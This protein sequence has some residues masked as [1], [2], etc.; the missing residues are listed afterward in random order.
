MAR[1]LSTRQR[2]DLLF[3]V[4]IFVMGMLVPSVV[5]PSPPAHS[6][7]AYNLLSLRDCSEAVN[8][9]SVG[10]ALGF[11]GFWSG[12][13][14]N[15]FLSLI[16]ALKLSWSNAHTLIAATNAL[17]AAFFYLRQRRHAAPLNAALGSAVIV[18][19]SVTVVRAPI[20]WNPTIVPPL[21]TLCALVFLEAVEKKNMFLF[22][23]A[24]LLLT[25]VIDAHAVGLLLV[26]AAIIATLLWAPKPVAAAVLCPL[27]AVCVGMA[28]SPTAARLNWIALTNHGFAGF[29]GL[30]VPAAFGIWL[31]PKMTRLPASSV[32]GAFTL[33][34]L[35]CTFLLPR[36][37]S[38][39]LDH[40]MASRYLAPS[41][42]FVAL[43]ATMSLQRIGSRLTIRFPDWHNPL[44]YGLALVALLPMLMDFSPGSPNKL[45]ALAE[46]WRLDD[47]TELGRQFNE[48]H[49]RFS[50]VHLN[51]RTPFSFH[52]LSGIGAAMPSHMKPPNHEILHEQLILLPHSFLKTQPT[53]WNDLPRGRTPASWIQVPSNIRMERSR[54]CVMGRDQEPPRCEL[55]DRTTLADLLDSE[56]TSYRQRTVPT[57]PVLDR[58]MSRASS[59]AQWPIR[60]RLEIQVE[61]LHSRR[62]FI[63]LPESIPWEIGAVQRNGI[64]SEMHARCIVLDSTGNAPVVLEMNAVISQEQQQAAHF[65]IPALIDFDPNDKRLA[66]ILDP[67]NWAIAS[68]ES[69]H[70][71]VEPGR[72]D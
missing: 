1:P 30:A 11:G 40:S 7:T 52:L 26:P 45:N 17:I 28:I 47:A 14:W 51:L 36:I 43:F 55:L 41:V 46:V 64:R 67:R 10:N 4:L 44:R 12:N 42:G 31:R 24:W 72:S 27:A 68:S 25:L 54:A 71:C 19:L 65:V 29:V 49:L 53:E 70:D 66:P 60:L 32:R 8:C 57:F 15:D 22:T 61:P 59:S 18:L 50:D 2:I 13:L 38:A 58:L 3:A 62:T 9:Q 69:A 6:D 33:L 56:D 5:L 20:L 39:L 23:T 21:A 16:I 34:G 35:F 37:L 48:D 63:L